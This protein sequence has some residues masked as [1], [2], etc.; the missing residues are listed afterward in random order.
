MTRS[1]DFIRQLEGYLDEYEGLTPLPEVV[2]DATRAELPKTKQ[3]G[4]LPGPIRYLSMSLSMPAPARYGLVAVVVVTA[5][6]LGAAFFRPAGNIGTD[7]TPTPTP[8]TAVLIEPD[9]TEALGALTAGTYY[10]DS[11]FPV[12]VTFDVPQGWSAWGYTSAG[13]QINLNSGSDSE[14]SFEIVDNIAADPCTGQLLDPPVGP[15]VDELVTALSNLAGFEASAATD[16]TVD[17]FH[18]KQFT[19]TAPDIDAPCESMLTWK[20]TTRHN[21]V[22]LG[23][24]NEV[25]ILDV[26]G[27]RLLICIAYFPPITKADRSELEAIVDSAQIGR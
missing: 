4:S 7:P 22:G 25:R 20:T 26:D 6:I 8:T 19:L 5:A 2:R 27:V 14:V 24:V 15:S 12:R 18:G 16:I 13:S 10:V 11:P 21:G 23:E 17:G 3:I 1:D 9:S